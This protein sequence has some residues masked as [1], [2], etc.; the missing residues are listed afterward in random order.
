ML[1]QITPQKAHHGECGASWGRITDGGWRWLA[2][3]AHMSPITIKL[4]IIHRSPCIIKIQ[5]SVHFLANGIRLCGSTPP[6]R[7]MVDGS[8]IEPIDDW[9]DRSCALSVSIDGDVS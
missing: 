7:F 5:E 1:L 6:S 9:V 4:G 8:G 3:T 2:H